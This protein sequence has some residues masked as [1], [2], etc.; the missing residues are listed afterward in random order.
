MADTVDVRR[1]EAGARG[2]L[3]AQP[4]ERA[5]PR[6]NDMPGTPSKGASGAGGAPC[7]SFQRRRSLRALAGL[8]AGCQG[9]PGHAQAG[10]GGAE[11]CGL[12]HATNRS[13]TA[14]RPTARRS[15][16]CTRPPPFP[17]QAPATPTSTSA[18]TGRT[19]CAWRWTRE[20]ATPLLGARRVPAGAGAPVS[21][22]GAVCCACGRMHHTGWLPA[23]SPA[24]TALLLCQHACV[25]AHANDTP[26]SLPQLAPHSL[27]AG[28]ATPTS[29]SAC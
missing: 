13:L 28:P 3:D 5:P 2:K 27:A 15:F 6:P 25:S 4:A 10:L 20:R 19:A 8:L 16:T 23:C 24:S 1:A 11:A 14:R 26:P 17:L 12:P 22:A 18:P 7:A 9:R 21:A 29:G